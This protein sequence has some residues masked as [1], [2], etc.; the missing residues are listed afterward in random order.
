MKLSKK[1]SIGLSFIICHLSL[2]VALT[3]CDDA[4]EY[5]DANTD[6]PSWVNNYNDSTAVAHP[7]TLANTKW[8]R[9]TG[10]KLNAYGQDVQGFVESLDFVTADSV[11]VKMSQGTTE[12]TWVDDS[13]TEALPLYEYDYSSTTGK[14][15]IKQRVENKGK[16]TK[17]D[18]FEGVAVSGKKETITLVHY[19]DTPAQT[20]LVRQ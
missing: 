14:L 5:E 16:V 19:G 11:A 8:V 18:I 15:K 7:E 1:L 2:S 20:Y 4:N 3:S 10:I 12:G 6:N 9:G 13:N 17:N